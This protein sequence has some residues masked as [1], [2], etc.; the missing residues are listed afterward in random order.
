MP[1]P[2]QRIFLMQATTGVNQTCF[3]SF[4]GTSAATPVVS[5][6]IALALEAK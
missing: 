3:Q 1:L 6:T 5:A 4:G 2:K